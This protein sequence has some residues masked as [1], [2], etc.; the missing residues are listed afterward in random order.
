MARMDRLPPQDIAAIEDF[1]DGMWAERGLADA[2]LAAYRADLAR[3]AEWLD[4][5]TDLL[6]ADYV[7]LQAWLAQLHGADTSA[8]SAAR[9][10]SSLRQ[11]YRYQVREGRRRQD[12]TTQIASPVQGRRLPT[13]LEETDVEALLTAPDTDTDLGLRDR[14]MLELMYAAGLRVSELVRAS[15]DQ[16]NLQQGVIHVLGKGG[17]ERLVP[18]GDTALDW[19]RRYLTTARPALLAG[20]P[21]DALFVSRRGSGMTRQNVWYMIRRHATHAGIHG[22]VSPHGLRHAFATHLL[23]HGADLRVVQM[24]LGHADLSTT[25]I[26]THVARARLAELHAQHHPRG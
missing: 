1:L 10:L 5:R 20:Q 23:N 14:A 22:H 24:L 21:G 6:D 12:P 2:T 15:Y 9:A 11:F 7:D 17:R 4:G 25:Q 18:V 26:Y 19:L 3:F 13:T 8:R 16:L